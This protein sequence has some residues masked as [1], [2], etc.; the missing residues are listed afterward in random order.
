MNEKAPCSLRLSWAG[1]L[2][3]TLLLCLENLLV[4]ARVKFQAAFDQQV[5]RI[6]N[7]V[8]L[9]SFGGQHLQRP[10]VD[11]GGDL[12]FVARFCLRRNVSHR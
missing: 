12:G 3:I 6:E 11:T 7:W 8:L 5:V 4:E 9:R 10:D 1:T 2:E